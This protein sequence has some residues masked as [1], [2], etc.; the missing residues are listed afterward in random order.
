MAYFQQVSTW[1]G[2]F[3]ASSINNG[4]S[5]KAILRVSSEQQK[6]LMDENT[7]EASS[8]VFDPL[9]QVSTWNCLYHASGITNG[10]HQ[11]VN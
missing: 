7:K 9:D 10:I 6:Q 8:Q 5:K 4:I 11:E 2:L 1:D 3:H